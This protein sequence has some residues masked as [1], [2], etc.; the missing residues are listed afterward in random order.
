MCYN[1]ICNSM[2]IFNI[3]FKKMCLICI[4]KRKGSLFCIL[5]NEIMT[6]KELRRL[7]RKELLEL[8]IAE[9]KEK[10][11]LAKELEETRIQLSDRTI[12]IQNAGTLAE[13]VFS[14]NGVYK[15]VDEAAQQYLENIKKRDEECRIQCEKI[16]NDARI[17]ADEIIS[18]AKKKAEK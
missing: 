3:Y 7:S 4:I 13:A 10:Q 1:T 17:K 6:D 11:K 12:D 8:L 16:L 5:R 14:L 18:E 2:S 15:A 9:E